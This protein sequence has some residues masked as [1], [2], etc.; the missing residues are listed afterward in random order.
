MTKR[1][2]LKEVAE[3]WCFFILP[4]VVMGSIHE[5]VFGL[6]RRQRPY[7]EIPLMVDYLFRLE[8]QFPDLPGI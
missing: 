7:F 3:S 4:R 6:T 2:R 8:E 1:I 5:C